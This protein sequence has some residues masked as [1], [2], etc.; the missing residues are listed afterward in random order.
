MT[1]VRDG[2]VA[3]MLLRFKRKLVRITAAKLGNCSVHGI[4]YIILNDYLYRN[5]HTL[6]TGH[7]VQESKCYPSIPGINCLCE[8]FMQEVLTVVWI[9]STAVKNMS[10]RRLALIPFISSVSDKGD[11]FPHPKYTVPV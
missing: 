3:E 7:L 9:K 11:I 8:I 10:I 1:V 4:K 5:T 2:E 6:E